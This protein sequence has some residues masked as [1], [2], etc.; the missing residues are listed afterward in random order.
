MTKNSI[1]NYAC[2]GEKTINSYTSDHKLV[3][4]YWVEIFSSYRNITFQN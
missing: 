1:S 3:S 4:F 2:Y